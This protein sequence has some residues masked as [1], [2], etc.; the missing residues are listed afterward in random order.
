MEMNS[1]ELICNKWSQKWMNLIEELII[2]YLWLWRLWRQ[3][4]SCVVCDR[5]VALVTVAVSRS[6][7]VATPGSSGM[8]LRSWSWSHRSYNTFIHSFIHSKLALL[9]II[10]IVIIANW[11]YVIAFV[12][13]I[14]GGDDRAATVDGIAVERSLVAGTGSGQISALNESLKMN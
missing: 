4:D 3:R 8:A 14:G 1:F 13:V 6:S 12:I 5:I 11:H 10:I 2:G 9:I 7:D